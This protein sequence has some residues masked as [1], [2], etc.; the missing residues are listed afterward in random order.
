MRSINEPQKRERLLTAAFAFLLLFWLAGIFAPLAFN[1]FP[2]L[3]PAYPF[4]KESYSVVCHQS[5]VKS[6][7]IGSMQLM[8]CARCLGIYTGVFA[9]LI[10]ALLVAARPFSFKLLI[11]AAIVLAIDVLLTTAGLYPYMKGLALI[12]GFL[13]GGAA[14]WFVSGYLRRRR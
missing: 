13:F 2:E 1:A 4:L 6:F 8:V 12:T 5:A 9:G 14:A 7:H 11:L 3:L 10:A